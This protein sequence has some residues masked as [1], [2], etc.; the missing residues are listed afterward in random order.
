MPRVPRSLA[1]VKADVCSIK[2][3]YSIMK[4]TL[5]SWDDVEVFLAVLRA[6]SF[7][8]GA[9]ALDTNQSTVSRRVLQME[10]Y[11]DVKLF[12]RSKRGA[13]PTAS[14]RL[15]QPAAETIEE[16]VQAIERGVAGIDTEMRG[17]V[18]ITATEGIGTFW[19]GPRMLG[20]QRSHPGIDLY[21]DATS[22]P[23]ELG[24]REA[25]I[26]IRFGRPDVPAYRIRQVAKVTFRAFGSRAYLREF[27]LPQGFQD[28]RDHLFVDYDAPLR[29]PLWT[30]W[31]RIVNSG[32]A[33]VLRSNST[34]AV[35]RAC[36]AGYGLA[37]LPLFAP[38][39]HPHILEVPVEIGPPLELWVATHEET[40]NSAR[41]RAAL[42]YIY[43]LFEVDRY[44]YFSG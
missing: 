5:N 26:A 42:D 12:D 11:L 25:D 31:R 18:K 4:R 34:H 2:R 1:R 39:Y 35:G 10:R 21:I 30:S 14:A 8:G 44:R 22:E 43:K 24:L 33:T 3:R 38:D 36:D 40:G 23:R 19:L 27:G 32:K 29:G 16:Q 20:F 15:I 28:F 41:V 6:G 37:L 13:R 7:L 17:E 9:K